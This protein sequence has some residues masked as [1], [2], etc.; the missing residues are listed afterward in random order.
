MLLWEIETIPA[1]LGIKVVP[2][3]E[4]QSLLTGDLREK[5]KHK[6]LSLGD[7]ACLALG[8]YLKLPVITADRG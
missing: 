3:D 5:T 8:K 6:V 2:F 4:N 7:K 1:T